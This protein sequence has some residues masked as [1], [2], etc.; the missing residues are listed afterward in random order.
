MALKDWIQKVENKEDPPAIMAKVA[1]EPEK[2]PQNS[3]NSQNSHR[4][5]PEMKHSN[6]I[7]DP[8]DFMIRAAIEDL[9]R[10]GKTVLDIPPATRHKAL[11]LEEQFTQAANDGNRE[12]FIKLLRQWRECFH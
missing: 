5:S 4:A 11:I 7:E 6:Q 3:N 2:K 9:D 8:F 10:C 1:I 12:E